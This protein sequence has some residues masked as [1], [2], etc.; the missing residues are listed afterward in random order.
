MCSLRPANVYYN[1]TIKI[2]IVLTN[3]KKTKFITKYN[4]LKPLTNKEKYH[5]KLLKI[6]NFHLL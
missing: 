6:C 2:C 1:V 5:A 4:V 3:F